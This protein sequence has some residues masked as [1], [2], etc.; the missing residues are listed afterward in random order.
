[1][2]ARH[3]Q[4]ALKT[5]NKQLAIRRAH[6]IRSRIE[7]GQVA[8]KVFKLD[9][10]CL[11]DRY[12]EVK[13]NENRAPKTIEKY[14]CG[15]VEF[16]AWCRQTG[17]GSV[18]RFGVADFWAF[19][20]WMA[21]R[22]HSEKTRYDRL[23]L[24]KQAFKYAARE[25]L[26]PEN[27]LAGVP[28]NKPEPT[29][30]PC[31]TPQQVAALLAKA[32]PHEAAIFAALAYLGL[33]VGEARDLRWADVHFKDD[34]TGGW[35]TVKRGGSR[36]DRTKSG[37]S[38]RIPL[39]PALLP[40][41]N[42]LPRSFETVFAARPSKKHPRGGAPIS[43]RRLLVSLKRL[44]KRCGFAD[45]RRYKVHSFRHAFASMC[46]RNNVAHKYALEWMG[47]RSSDILDLYYTQYDDVAEQAIRTISY[48]G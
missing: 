19:N 26:I 32:D 17:R 5:T 44:C 8:P 7:D 29:E 9:S 25:K 4:Q 47:H 46:A 3:Y 24:I 45:W 48:T 31:F 40:Y 42:T 30:Q 2:H 11:K 16:D 35:V 14:T 20:G 36:P 15:L 39:N 23:V 6:D 38:R 21:E 41:L 1:V 28:M 18:V 33:R 12:L 27:L 10:T 22:G 13:R 37:R 34:G 43:E